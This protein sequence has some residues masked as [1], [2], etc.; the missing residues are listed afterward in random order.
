MAWEGR[1]AAT[2]GHENGVGVGRRA[3]SATARLGRPRGS[4]FTPHM[5][6]SCLCHHHHHHCCCSCRAPSWPPHHLGG[7]CGS[8]CARAAVRPGCGCGA[9]C[10]C[11]CCSSCACCPCCSCA[12]CPCCSCAACCACR[13][14]CRRPARPLRARRGRCR[15]LAAAPAAAVNRGSSSS[16]GSMRCQI[17]DTQLLSV[18]GDC[19]GAP[20]TLGDR[21]RRAR[22]SLFLQQ[23]Q[24]HALAP[25]PA[26]PA[27]AAASAHTQNTHLCL[28]EA[29][30]LFG[31]RP[32]LG[33]GSKH[34]LALI[35]SQAGQ[36]RLGLCA[37]EHTTGSCAEWRSAR[38]D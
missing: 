25:R 32:L 33:Q 11:A 28:L 10:P 29:C 16:N 2:K 17:N 15:R 27:A 4:V 21:S 26:D 12:C 22:R 36:Q 3:N 19:A 38:I 7:G 34:G 8:C 18:E 24:Q 30:R 5:I 1:L 9:D 31:A 23:Q 13:A 35:G 6:T 20:P 37:P 14:C